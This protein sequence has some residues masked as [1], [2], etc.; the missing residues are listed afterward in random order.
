[1][2]STGAAYLPI[3]GASLSGPDAASFRI[4]ENNC[5][6]LIQPQE[7]CGVKVAFDPTSGADG[8]RNAALVVDAFSSVKAGPTS[9]ALTG[10]AHVPVPILSLKLKSA[11]KVK[12]GRTLVVKATVRN[13]GDA[14]ASSIRLKTT[15]PKKFTKKVKAI[16]VPSLAAGKSVTKKIKV[17]VRKSAKKGKTLRVKVVASA[18]GLSMKTASRTAKIK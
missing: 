4:I 9:V 12:R 18:S 14:T 10:T 7:V 15:V 3:S 5:A 11:K 13:T 1:V 2:T 16:K 8:V 6:P 17:K